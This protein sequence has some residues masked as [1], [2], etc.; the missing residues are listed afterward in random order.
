MIGQDFLKLVRCPQSGDRLTLAP[1]EVIQQANQAI[2]ERKLD[3]VSG[4]TVDKELDSGLINADRSIL[5]PIRDEIV[6]LI[7]DQ[8]IALDQLDR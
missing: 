5:Y 7:A 6:T 3:D 4:Q 2:R 8:G 1:D